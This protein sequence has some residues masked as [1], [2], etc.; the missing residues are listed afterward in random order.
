MSSTPVVLTNQLDFDRQLSAEVARGLQTFLSGMQL[1]MDRLRHRT[2]RP[3]RIDHVRHGH[4]HQ[5]RHRPMR[6]MRPH[7]MHHQRQA[8]QPVPV[9]MLAGSK[10]HHQR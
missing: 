6:W 1:F 7:G 10:I 9:K 5:R 4:S 2:G 8:M 3:M